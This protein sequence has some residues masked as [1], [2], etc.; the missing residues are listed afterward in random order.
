M[1]E[2]QSYENYPDFHEIFTIRKKTIIRVT[3]CH[4]N[5]PKVRLHDGAAI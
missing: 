5:I 2:F 3:G 1:A 4:F